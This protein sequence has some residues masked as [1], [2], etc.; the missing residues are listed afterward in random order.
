MLNH[1]KTPAQLIAKC[2]IYVGGKH[3]MLVAS[4]D[5][6]TETGVWCL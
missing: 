1:Q 2:A 4:F 3:K 5:I 6:S